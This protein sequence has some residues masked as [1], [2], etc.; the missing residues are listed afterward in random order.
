M[1]VTSCS[2]NLF[3]II[4][5][6]EWGWL[7]NKITKKNIHTYLGVRVGISTDFKTLEYD[8][9]SDFCYFMPISGAEYRFNDNFGIGG[10]LGLSFLFFNES[11]YFLSP[12][13]EN[14]PYTETWIE[15]VTQI[16]FRFYY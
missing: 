9:N 16:F 8:N 14:K 7:F 2:A 11:D 4:I 3:T 5:T 12:D 10:E 6:F 15:L 1:N 13:E